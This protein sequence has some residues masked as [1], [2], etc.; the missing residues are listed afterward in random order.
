DVWGDGHGA[1]TWFLLEGLKGKADVAGNYNGIVTITEAFDYLESK[2]RRA[3]Q[4]AQHPAITGDFDNNLPLGFLQ[5][6]AK[7]GDPGQPKEAVGKEPVESKGILSLESTV[8]NAKIYLNGKFIGKTSS[9]ESFEKNIS[10]GVVKLKVKKNGWQDYKR[11]V[12]IN[13]NETS[14]VYVAMRS[15]QVPGET[16]QQGQQAVTTT[17][18]NA[19]KERYIEPKSESNNGM[20]PQVR[21]PL[22]FDVLILSFGDTDWRNTV[23][24]IAGE[25]LGK[26]EGFHL[27][28]IIEPP[29]YTTRYSYG[30]DS[31]VIEDFTN[32]LRRVK[33]AAVP[34]IIVKA[35]IKTIGKTQLKFYDNYKTLYTTSVSLE[36]IL[37][38]NSQVIAG[39]IIR[40]VKFTDINMYDNMTTVVRSMAATLA[41]Q[42][43][44]LVESVKEK[45]GNY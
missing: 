2:V 26:S 40:Q 4:N 1:F 13:P 32:A 12:Y 7:T 27:V 17:T 29:G 6:A 3:T 19:L 25:E 34:Y 20:T 42:I 23:K 24:M 28:D 21:K 10:P 18:G 36:A 22:V 31:F 33:D 37:T 15:V 14:N 35:N 11:I 8:D 43:K 41:D 5:I 38:G 45:G 44:G 16:A 39:P 30:I 9:N